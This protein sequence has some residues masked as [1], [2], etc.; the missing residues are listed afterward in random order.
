M[1]YL[2]EMLTF[3]H[4]HG[5]LV[6][7]IR[8]D[9]NI[10]RSAT[11]DKPNSLEAWLIVIGNYIT[12]G[13]W[14]TGIKYTWHPEGKHL[15]CQDK[16]ELRLARKAYDVELIRKQVEALAH[17]QDIW[18]FSDTVKNH[19]YLNKKNINAHI[20]RLDHYSNLLIP[21][22][23]L[24]GELVSLQFISAD[25][26]KRFKRGGSLKG[27]AA[28]IG[29][30]NKASVVL[31]CEGYA[32]GCSLYEATQLPVVVAFNAGNLAL[33]SKAMAK[34]HPTIKLV[35]CADN[36]HQ[37]QRNTGVNVGLDKARM[38]A[39]QLNV[40]LLWPEFNPDNDGSDFNDV[41]CQQGLNAL[42]NMLMP[43]IN[44]GR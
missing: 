31:I 1:I 7:H 22:C 42:T 21:I 3:V 9:G 17:C 37:G 40:I 11:V 44:G 16:E 23:S 18:Q 35:I 25:G 14:R 41:H 28:L 4:E 24:D 32:T 38:V 29:D 12:V 43:A 13:N 2:D 26:Q 15:T 36:D 19:P 39:E 34:E 20:A 8:A 27:H 30:F 5:L 6:D 10:H 33:V